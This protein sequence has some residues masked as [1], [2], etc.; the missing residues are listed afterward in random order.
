M[1]KEAT[2]TICASILWIGY[3]VA[4]LIVGAP[5]D[6][7]DLIG[8][9]LLGAVVMLMAIVEAKPPS[10]TTVSSSIQLIVKD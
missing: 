1:T 10:N 7:L 5:F 6:L 3:V 2:I 8:S 4:H 9:F